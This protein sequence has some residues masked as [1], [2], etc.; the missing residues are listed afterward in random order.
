[1]NGKMTQQELRQTVPDA[2]DIDALIPC[3][4]KNGGESTCILLAS[5]KTRLYRSAIQTI[6]RIYAVREDKEFGRVGRSCA[7]LLGRSHGTIYP[8]S[9]DLTLVGLKM[10]SKGYSSHHST[11][12]YVNIAHPLLVRKAGAWPYGLIVF[13]SG[14]QLATLWHVRTVSQKLDQARYIYLRHFTTARQRLARAE[15][16]LPAILRE[17]NSTAYAVQEEN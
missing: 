5:G 16:T 3:T 12:A 4:D 13:A 8:I 2:R 1:M 11:R 6:A 7:C 15:R 9:L 17:D 10:R 14:S